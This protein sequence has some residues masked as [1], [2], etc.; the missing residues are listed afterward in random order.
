[1]TYTMRSDDLQCV[2]AR[3]DYPVP[4]NETQRVE[5]LR[6]L[7]ILDTP[8]DAALDALV[9][10]AC[11][12]FNVPIGI[13]SLV[14]SDRQWFKAA[15]GLDFAE[16]ERRVAFCNFA[17]AEDRPFVVNDASKDPRFAANPL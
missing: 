17:L 11:E 1:M 16:T 4:K 8:R 5:M 6:S 13:I 10:L 2:Q 3:A 14:D 9:R 12:F 15:A 7:M